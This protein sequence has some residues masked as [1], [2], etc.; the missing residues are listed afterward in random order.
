VA[1]ARRLA[2]L[3]HL[4]RCFEL[5]ARRFPPFAAV[6]FTVLVLIERAAEQ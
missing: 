2:V 1:L 5:D 6:G 3:G 4:E